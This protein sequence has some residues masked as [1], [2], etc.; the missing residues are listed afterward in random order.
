M[1]LCGYWISSVCNDE[2]HFKLKSLLTSPIGDFEAII[3]TS[4]FLRLRGLLFREPLKD[5]ECIVLYPCRSIHTFGMK[6]SIDILF[7]DIFG[8]V[9]D[10]K[11]NVP[12]SRVYVSSGNSVTT[13]EI[14]SGLLCPNKNYHGVNFKY[15]N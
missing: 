6:Y 10:Y 11:L 13:I 9:V 4:F 15:K 14:K 7:L 8:Y 3:A 1:H 12:S 2:R 5:N